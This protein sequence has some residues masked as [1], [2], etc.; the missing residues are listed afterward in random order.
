MQKTHFK[1]GVKIWVFYNDEDKYKMTLAKQIA[2]NIEWYKTK[3]Q[4]IAVLKYINKG[5]LIKRRARKPLKK[6]SILIQ[7]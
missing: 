5:Q 3:E 2:N 7:N 4:A 6:W 1:N